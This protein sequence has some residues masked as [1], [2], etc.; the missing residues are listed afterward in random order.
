MYIYNVYQLGE[1]IYSSD[2]GLTA[3]EYARLT[4]HITGVKC[5]VK[6]KRK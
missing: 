6:R 4:N 5:T 1:V 2:D 3:N